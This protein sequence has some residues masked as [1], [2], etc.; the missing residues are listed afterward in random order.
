MEHLNLPLITE[1][2]QTAHNDFLESVGEIP[3]KISVD[4]QYLIIRMQARIS[5][6]LKCFKTVKIIDKI[7]E[8]MDREADRSSYCF[9]ITK[10]GYE[11][12]VYVWTDGINIIIK[13]P[14][15]PPSSGL[16]FD[17]NVVVRNVDFD[18]HNW[19]EFA[20]QLIHYIHKV[21]YSRRAS[22]E[23]KFLRGI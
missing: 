12:S 2:I 5:S 7:E 20:D 13:G 6:I 10:K 14:S 11:K 21:M 22:I 4:H 19:V 3:I 17:D 18:S 23:A 9:K 16:N 1:R 15:Y 8:G